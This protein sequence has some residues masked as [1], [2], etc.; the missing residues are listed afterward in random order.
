MPSK[1]EVKKYFQEVWRNQP[2]LPPRRWLAPT[3]WPAQPESPLAAPLHSSCLGKSA[4]THDKERCQGFGTGLPRSWQPPTRGFA[5]VL[6]FKDEL[7]HL[8]VVYISR[9]SKHLGLEGR[10]A[11]QG[12]VGVAESACVPVWGQVR[13]QEVTSNNIWPVI[14]LFIS[15]GFHITFPWEYAPSLPLFTL[16]SASGNCGDHPRYRCLSSF[17]CIS[18]ISYVQS[19][20]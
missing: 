19:L 12:S 9:W 17:I 7:R 18:G 4:T 5:A 10:A 11:W 1:I 20:T 14:L 6:S 13:L 2:S 15:H 16:P 8:L 3:C